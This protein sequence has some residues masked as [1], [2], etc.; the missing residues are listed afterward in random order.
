MRQVW[1]GVNTTVNGSG[2]LASSGPTMIN[3]DVQFGRP[4]TRI[5]PNMP[6]LTSGANAG[7]SYLLD[8]ALLT[9]RSI[10]GVIKPSKQFGSPNCGQVV[11]VNNSLLVHILVQVL[12]AHAD[13]YRP[14][15]IP[16]FGS[17]IMR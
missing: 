6:R 13:S 8:Q 2:V 11:E 17:L 16:Q 1:L 12:L 3:R 9:E 15:L 5:R 4:F 10:Q 14:V 7:K